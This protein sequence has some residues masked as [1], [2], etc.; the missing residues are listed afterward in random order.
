MD[1]ESGL[2]RTGMSITEEDMYIIKTVYEDL[3]YLKEEWD[4]SIEDSSLR[5]NSNVL[6]MLLVDDYFSKAWRIVGFKRQPTISATDL[7][8]YVMS[9]RRSGVSYA[10]AGGAMYEGMAVRST[11]MTNYAMTE[12]EIKKQYER[13]SKQPSIKCFSVSQLMKSTCIIV[14]GKSISRRELIKY[15]SNKLGGTHIDTRRDLKNDE[16]RKFADLD[17]LTGMRLANKMAVYYELLSIGQAVAHAEDTQKYCQRT[18]E[19]LK[20]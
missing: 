2:S 11:V 19:I 8:G 12:A 14:N 17:K 4:E 6:R 9:V 20:I 5:R 15:V 10:Q 1:D 16:G 18:A 7:D 13:E 3:L